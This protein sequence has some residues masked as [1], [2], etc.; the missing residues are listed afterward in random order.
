MVIF[1]HL[2]NLPVTELEEEKGCWSK[3]IW[4]KVLRKLKPC[5]VKGKESFECKIKW[6]AEVAILIMWRSIEE[7]SQH[8]VL[9]ITCQERTL[10]KITELQ[11][12]WIFGVSWYSLL[13]ILYLSN[14]GKSSKGLM[15]FQVFISYM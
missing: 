6:V 7:V 14:I 13:F 15:D 2:F 4:G 8:S 5:Q 10:Q 3:G 1:Q 9:I 11:N 12:S